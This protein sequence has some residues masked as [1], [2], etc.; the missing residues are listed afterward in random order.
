[1]TVAPNMQTAL[2]KPVS[3]GAAVDPT[4]AVQ[5]QQVAGG[6]T[7]A[8]DYVRLF[9]DV[10]DIT[11]PVELNAY[12]G[13]NAGVIDVRQRT[14][15]TDLYCS[16]RFDG[17]ATASANGRTIVAGLADP[18]YTNP[19]WVASGPYNVLGEINQEG[20]HV[21]FADDLYDLG[22][23]AGG[24]LYWHALYVRFVRLRQNASDDLDAVPKQQLDS[25]I[26]ISA[27]ASISNPA[28]ELATLTGS[29]GSLLFIYQAA[30]SANDDGALYEFDTSAGATNVPYVVAG[31]G[32]KWIAKAGRFTNGSMSINGAVGVLGTLSA[33]TTL[34]V[35]GAST[36]S[37]AVS[38][39]STLG[40]AGIMT[41]STQPC[42][43]AS[44]V[45]TATINSGADTS[46]TFTENVD[47]GSNFAAS[48]FTVP[49][50]GAG[51]YWIAGQVSLDISNVLG[52]NQQVN[53]KII[54]N[55]V[56]LI[57]TFPAVTGTTN[58]YANGGVYV[59]LSVADQVTMKVRQD[60]GYS[61][62]LTYAVFNIAKFG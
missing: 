30:S 62:T 12:N 6:G 26:Q 48:T 47:R 13:S 60:S 15:P 16:Y 34:S 11:A 33:S 14:S 3:V 39:G 19:V 46:I 29:N 5:L 20:N 51:V 54:K 18:S 10:V 22:R 21:P 55:G 8:A 38:A 49:S 40:V 25:K 59:E 52:A 17:E 41:L 43:Q 61:A 32:G 57:G 58:A 37:G 9:I 4:H 23:I 56:T 50:G 36:L 7:G 24:D 28:A 31:S 27:V 35:T 2:D 53:I 1:M 42:A 44:F 45:G